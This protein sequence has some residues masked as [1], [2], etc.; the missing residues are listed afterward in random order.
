LGGSSVQVTMLPQAATIAKYFHPGGG[1]LNVD[2]SP[3]ADIQTDRLPISAAGWRRP[4]VI[5]DSSNC[6]RGVLARA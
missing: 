2:Y 1:S 4:A 3:F 6:N 5:K